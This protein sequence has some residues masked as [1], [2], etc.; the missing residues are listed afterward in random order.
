MTKHSIKKI[1]QL[2]FIIFDHMSNLTPWGSPVKFTPR[3]KFKIKNSC[4]LL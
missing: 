4:L 1:K 3:N 2:K